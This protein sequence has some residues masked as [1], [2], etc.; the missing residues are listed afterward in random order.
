MAI[1]K[2]QKEK[3]REEAKVS[4]KRKHSRK[5]T[6]YFEAV[7]DG[8]FGVKKKDHINRIDIPSW[9]QLELLGLSDDSSSTQQTTL[10]HE[11]DGEA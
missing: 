10:Q 2:A 4:G 6:K 11:R 9:E 5:K 1:E 7:E 3:A 8:A